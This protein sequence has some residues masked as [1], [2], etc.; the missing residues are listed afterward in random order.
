M[1]PVA[2]VF[3]DTSMIFAA[4]ALSFRIGTP[5]DLLAWLRDQ[6]VR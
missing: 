2:K 6:A 1:L 3:L 4:E 5:G